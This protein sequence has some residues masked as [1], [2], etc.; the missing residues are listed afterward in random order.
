MDQAL[1]FL[2]LNGYLVLFGIVLAEQ[3]GIPVPSVPLLLSA[4]ALARTGHLD[5]AVVI[6]LTVIAAM[7]ADVIWFEIGRRRGGKVLSWLCR[8]SLEP[9][10]CV[11]RTEDAFAAHGSRSLLVAKFIP[12]LSTLAPP[13]AG[14]LKTPWFR[15][16][17]FDLMGTVLWATLF[18]GL[19]YLL[20]EQLG[21]IAKYAARL[22]SLMIAILAVLLGSYVGWRYLRRRRSMS[23][24]P[25]GAPPSSAS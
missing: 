12:G 23:M 10:S 8:F 18:S 24:E 1:E 20:G 4:G 6:G 22:G 11:R 7:L 19:G 15:F 5:L 13:L 2:I 17:T 9:D 3:I 16:L 25:Q 14:V 21:L